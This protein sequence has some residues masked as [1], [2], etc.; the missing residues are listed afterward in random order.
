VPGAE[1]KPILVEVDGFQFELDLL[2]RLERPVPLA[3][4][5]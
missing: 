1:S 2:A 4:D 5:P 3:V